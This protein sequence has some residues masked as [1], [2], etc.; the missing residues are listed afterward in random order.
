MLSFNDAINQADALHARITNEARRAA[1]APPLTDAERAASEQAR[2]TA[3]S[4]LNSTMALVRGALHAVRGSRE[5]REKKDE[6]KFPFRANRDVAP[7]ALFSLGS[8]VST[9]S[10]SFASLSSPVENVKQEMSAE[11]LKKSTQT[12]TQMAEA[13]E[14]IITSFDQVLVKPYLKNY[15]ASL[16]TVPVLG[17]KDNKIMYVETKSNA[18]GSLKDSWALFS[19]LPQDAEIKP[20][21]NVFLFPFKGDICLAIGQAVWR[22]LH[23][24]DETDL[25]KA[26][27]NWPNMYQASWVKVGDNVL[28]AADLRSV[29]PFAVLSADRQN[30][31]FHLVVLKADSS[32]AV[33]TSD[34][35]INNASFNPLTFGP[36]KEITTEPKW[37]RIAYWDNQ[38]VGY[39]DANNVYNLDVKF[40]ANSFTVSDKTPDTTITELTATEAGL[41]V[42]RSDGFLYKRLIS[43]PKDADKD[44]TFS[45]TKWIS[46]DG[47]TNLGV[48]SPGVILDLNLLTRTLRSRYIEV[49][50]AVYPMVDGIRAFCVTHNYYL[51]QLQTAADTYNS[52]TEPEEKKTLAIKQAKGFVVHAQ[53][54]SRILSS[55]IKGCKQE[56][57]IMTDQLKGVHRQLET[58]LTLLNDKLAGLKKTLETQKDAL[59][60]LQAAFWGM[61]GAMFLGMAL[62][63]LGLALGGNPLILTAAGVL[64]VGGLVAMVTL[65]IKMGEMAR[66]VSDTEAQIRDV[67]TAITEMTA[68]VDS[69]SDLDTKYGTLNE[70]WGRMF[71]DAS[72]IGTMDDATAAQLGMDILVDDSSIGAARDMT[73]QMGDACLKYLDVLNKQGI[74]VPDPSASSVTPMFLSLARNVTAAEPKASSEVRD[75]N[76]QFHQLVKVGQQCLA[77]GDLP[78]YEA[79]INQAVLASMAT[80]VAGI[81][82]QVMS[83]RWFDVASLRSNGSVWG[84]TSLTAKA[85]ALS[86]SDAAALVDQG[87]KM[88]GSLQQVRPYVVSMLQQTIQLGQ[89]VLDWS[90][91]FPEPPTPDKEAEVDALQKKSLANC[92]A[93][94]SSAAKAKNSFSSFQ[95]EA[96]K[97]QQDL[98]R[99]INQAKNDIDGEQSRANSDMNHI[100]V[101]W[102]VYLGGVVAVTTYIAV[103]RSEI[104]NR[105]HRTVASLQDNIKKLKELEDSGASFQGSALTWIEMC[106]RVSGNLGTIYNILT[107]LQGQVMENPVFYNQLMKTEWSEIVKDASEVLN[108]IE[109]SAP[110]TL[111]AFLMPAGNTMMLARG[112]TMTLAATPSVSNATL[113]TSL[114]PDSN[115]GPKMKDQAASAD[116]VFDQMETLLRLPHLGD[117]IAYWDETKTKKTTLLNVATQL[118]TQYVQLAATEY[119]TIQHLYSLAIL[120]RYRADNVVKGK[121]PIDAFVKVSLASLTQAYKSANR[122]ASEFARSASDFDFAMRQ[123]NSNIKTIQEKIAKL[124]VDIETMEKK[125][126]DTIIWLIADIIALSFATAAFLAS[127]GAFGPLTSAVALATRIGLGATATA[128]SI[129]TVIDSLALADVVMLISTTK[130]VKRDLEKSAEELAK[131][132]PRFQNVVDGVTAISSSLLQMVSTL[133]KTLD[134]IEVLQQFTLT[135]ADVEKIGNAW[136][137]VK[138][139]SQDWMDVVNRQGISPVTFSI[140]SPNN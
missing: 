56:V 78:G 65:G 132:Q 28:P 127:F 76:A 12:L 24:K 73:T 95:D 67:T 57:N 81:E 70:F 61:V 21:K 87:S 6:P 54:W 32:M 27:D 110:A 15:N 8:A 23:Y 30:I 111:S 31:D 98:E 84:G 117:I 62:A 122:A 94:Q 10:P 1:N 138:N 103:Q 19:S 25:K 11:G 101:P 119:D 97:Y 90:S 66:A 7:Q 125:Q 107:A 43:I 17:I 104:Q 96:T 134:N 72:A 91:R 26:V 55:K 112:A 14:P 34:D 63:V 136:D 71:V 42:A 83:G 113:V 120:Q 47:V 36:S 137:I 20:G 133:S 126:R 2:L 99:N 89:V 13:I 4:S 35:L 115:L 102:Y 93:A 88:N 118:R 40:S 3:M 85:I 22:K 92:E 135:E 50:T 114:L 64:F 105:L 121:L 106:E 58:Q 46:Q 38:I 59:S 68:I 139:N 69:Y 129:K 41:V 16:N 80:E 5:A 77:S 86:I 82:A 131:V 51:Q 39:D 52:T 48:A 140:R 79:T 123:V 60:K 109:S 33:L 128:A 116:Q 75:C 53:T 130:D 49:Q 29:I 37:S 45:W 44:A 9:V 108:V 74:K 100:S 124:N 18:L